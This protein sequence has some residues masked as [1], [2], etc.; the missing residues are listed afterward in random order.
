MDQFV[1]WFLIHR[2]NIRASSLEFQASLG[3]STDD[4]DV[5]DVPTWSDHGNV[6]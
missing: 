4:P 6:D 5:L 2:P 3:S 1:D